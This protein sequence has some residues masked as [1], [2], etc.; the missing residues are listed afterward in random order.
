MP[1]P[2]SRRRAHILICLDPPSSSLASFAFVVVR[3]RSALFGRR[4]YR[5]CPGRPPRPAPATACRARRIL[6]FAGRRRRDRGPGRGAE[7]G[8][9]R[10][11]ARMPRRVLRRSG[12]NL[13]QPRRLPS[14]RASTTCRWRCHMHG[15]CRKRW[16]SAAGT[17][18]RR[19]WPTSAASARSDGAV[20]RAR[21]A[22]RAL[23]RLHR[24]RP[25]ARLRRRLLRPLAGGASATRPRSASPGRSP[26]STRRPSRRSRTTSRSTLIVTEQGVR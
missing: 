26:A 8:G 10:A 7:R 3:D 22:G 13:T 12:P 6:R 15:A 18:A 11:R 4:P 9:G 23:R 14:T 16:S 1:A 2:A 24:R 19:R 20:G 17:A 25:P 5:S 21:R